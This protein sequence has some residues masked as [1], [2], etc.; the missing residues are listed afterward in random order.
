MRTDVAVK[1]HPGK[2]DSR[3]SNPVKPAGVWPD[4]LRNCCLIDKYTRAICVLYFCWHY[5]VSAFLQPLDCGGRKYV[6][7][8]ME[9]IRE[10]KQENKEDVCIWLSAHLLLLLT[11][12][13]Q[14][15]TPVWL[16]H[17]CEGLSGY[18][19]THAAKVDI[20]LSFFLLST[21]FLSSTY[22]Y[23]MCCFPFSPPSAV[24]LSIILSPSSFHHP[25]LFSSGIYRAAPDASA[26]LRWSLAHA[27][28]RLGSFCS[29][30]AFS[31]VLLPPPPLSPCRHG[32]LSIHLLLRRGDC[33]IVNA[34]S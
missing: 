26:S 33:R 17:D 2:N 15:Q 27:C 30:F 6:E 20:I 10:G 32:C 1:V 11:S 16:Q 18:C 23:C 4:C 31:L 5:D 12:F 22:V 28:F 7:V 21:L 8:V 13:H 24:P 9:N 25:L 34:H 19:L 29:A 14:V 3:E